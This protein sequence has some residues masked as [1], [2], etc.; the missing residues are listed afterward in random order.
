[1][2]VAPAGGGDSTSDPQSFTITVTGVNDVPSFAKGTDIQT[3]E[4]TTATTLVFN[5]WASAVSAGPADEAGQTLTFEVTNNTNP[6][7][8]S[9]PPSINSSGDLSFRPTVHG[10]GTATITIRVHDTGGTA[11]GG[12]DTSADAD[13]PHRRLRH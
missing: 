4:A 1:M 5:P 10:T 8:F 9:T 2:T 7:L 3:P 12:E 6:S 13:V 11:N